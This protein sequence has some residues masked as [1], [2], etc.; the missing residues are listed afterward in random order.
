MSILNIY[1]DDG[2]VA[3]QVLMRASVSLGRHPENDIVLDDRTLS[4]FHA[5]VERRGDRYVVIDLGA[6]NGVYLNGTRITGESGLTPGDRIGLG[7]YVA[8]FDPHAAEG[9]GAREGDSFDDA[10]GLVAE[11]PLDINLD[12][13]LADDS[14]AEPT[15]PHGNGVRSEPST[16]SFT[17]A[18]P[19]N[20][21]SDGLI[22]ALDSVVD[23]AS[24]SEIDVDVEFGDSAEAD[25]EDPTTAIAKP[26]QPKAPPVFVL[27]YNQLE[28]SRH[29]MVGDELVVGRSKQ[30][31]IV[32]S[33]LGLS[34]RHARI[35]RE[36]NRLYVDDLGSQ[37]G[38][39]V[40]N[41]RIDGR[42]ALEHG[43]LMNFYEYGLLYLE[44]P[45]AEIQL[46]G[47]AFSAEG[48]AD[49]LEQQ[50]TGRR[51]PPA[52]EAEA[53]AHTRDRNGSSASS[54]PINDPEPTTGRVG[55]ASFD[56]D[57][58]GEGS[59]LEDAFEGGEDDGSLLDQIPELDDI[60][61]FGEVSDLVDPETP[62]S[63]MV[64]SDNPL[65]EADLISS[66]NLDSEIDSF[67]SP[68]EQT[69]ATASGHRTFDADKTAYSTIPRLGDAGGRGAWPTDVELEEALA[70]RGERK[71]MSLEVYLDEDLYTQMPLSQD[72]TRVGTDARCEVALPSA[73]GLAGW[74]M[75]VVRFGST[76]ILYRASN[77]ARVV[78]DDSAIDQAVLR[79]GDVIQL[80]RLKI[81]FKCR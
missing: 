29:P 62:G 31:E 3:E 22:D 51:G 78:L 41:V 73:A 45:N 32:I 44:D 80:G 79:D 13:I 46:P 64:G 66:L 37:N 12:D 48:N 76:A 52:A 39:W 54:L 24:V 30:C 42:R 50:E 60:S 53:A 33:L 9:R 2:F 21:G 71:L 43:D 49:V 70:R 47:V 77:N 14:V 19:A 55:S 34:R 16:Q 36:G 72:V 10:T 40:N 38:T 65:A 1:R 8:I 61:D 56:F 81:I 15:A 4:R 59:F 7:R 23:Q 28:V 6:Q 58:L 75:T 18:P 69:A 68:E 27:L 25:L 17:K 63:T 20:G 74:Q 57:A 26:R 35:A 11:S 67:S 5:R